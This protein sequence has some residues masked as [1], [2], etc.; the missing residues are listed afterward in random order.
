[1]NATFQMDIAAPIETVFDLV[2][3]DE[4][5]KQWMDG[6]EEISYPDGQDREDP[7][8]KR[9]NMKIREGGR[10]ADYE[11]EVLDYDKPNHLAISIGAHSF[12]M[13]VDYRFTS[14]PEG[15]RLDY[16][17]QP[18]RASFFIRFIG[19]C[20]SWLTKRILKKQMAALKEL[21]ERGQAG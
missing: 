6:V 4:K 3:D 19:F 20:F 17:C 5:I 8:G 10:V 15:T 13:R 16:V 9:F 18:L 1:M 2:D 14:I 11:G 21:A 7:V 12:S